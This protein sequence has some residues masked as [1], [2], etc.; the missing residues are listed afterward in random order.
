MDPTS[1][2][3]LPYFIPTSALRLPYF[4]NTPPSPTQAPPP[5]PQTESM[6]GGV[7]RMFHIP[8]RGLL[9][10]FFPRGRIL[11]ADGSGATG[12]GD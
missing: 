9:D 6:S 3:L 1:T 12:P 2:L 4:I 10:F 5:N 11:F 8:V 7:L